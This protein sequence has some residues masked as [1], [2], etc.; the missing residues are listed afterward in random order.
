MFSRKQ[1]KKI[2]EEYFF[3]K[4]IVFEVLRNSFLHQLYLHK[5]I[6]L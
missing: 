4:N 6:R 3:L 2:E 1:G 5:W